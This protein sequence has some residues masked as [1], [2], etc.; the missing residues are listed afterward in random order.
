MIPLQAALQPLSVATL[1]AAAD[2][3]GS[4]LRQGGKLWYSDGATWSDL[5]LS[6]GG[7]LN[8]LTASAAPASGNDST[9]GY[10]VG[11]RWLWAARGL[12]WVAVD[13]TPGAAV[14]ETTGQWLTVGTMQ[15]T[16]A[17]GALG[18]SVEGSEGVIAAT[19]TTAAFDRRRY[20]TAATANARG[21][22][23]VTT[24][25]M[26]SSSVTVPRTLLRH[27]IFLPDA[28]YGSGATPSALDIL[29]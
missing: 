23:S 19:A 22:A 24:G 8:N 20:A 7:V 17:V 25:R 5:A 2:F 4:L 12:E 3:T 18:R 15:G 26:F 28:S 29:T 16:T 11:S 6:G 10:A 14:W 21:S 13:V 27:R 9:Q 1:P